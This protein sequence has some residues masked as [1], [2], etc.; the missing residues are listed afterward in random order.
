MFGAPV[1]DL[2]TGGVEMHDVQCSIQNHSFEGATFWIFRILYFSHDES[3]NPELHP[4]KQDVGER[5]I[6]LPA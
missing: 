1:D 6:L 2:C 3:E 4:Y 5:G